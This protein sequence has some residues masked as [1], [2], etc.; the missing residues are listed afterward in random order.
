MSELLQSIEKHLGFIPT[1]KQG[2][3]M[4]A[5]SEFVYHRSPGDVFVL[6]G[7]AGTGKTSVV[8]ALVKALAEK[9]V[10]MVLLAPTGRAAKVFSS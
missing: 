2:I 1:D 9:N 4:V 5:L 3:L 7:Y 6:N 8:S 10:P